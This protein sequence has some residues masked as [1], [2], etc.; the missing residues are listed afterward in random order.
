MT[1]VKLADGRKGE[2]ARGETVTV[3]LVDG[4]VGCLPN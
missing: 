2:L 3:R 4:R 1:T